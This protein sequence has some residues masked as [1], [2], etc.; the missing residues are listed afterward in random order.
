MLVQDAE[1]RRRRLM[2]NHGGTVNML[3]E[4]ADIYYDNLVFEESVRQWT[5]PGEKEVMRSPRDSAQLLEP[6][7]TVGRH[8][9]S[10]RDDVTAS[11]RSG[12]RWTSLGSG[13]SSTS[14][15]LR[16][17]KVGGAM[18]PRRERSAS[19]PPEVLGMLRIDGAPVRGGD[20]H[21]RHTLGAVQYQGSF[22]EILNIHHQI[23]EKP[24][25]WLLRPHPEQI[26]LSKYVGL[27]DAWNSLTAKSSQTVEVAL[28]SMQGS[29]RATAI[30]RPASRPKP[31]VV[32]EQKEVHTTDIGSGADLPVSRERGGGSRDRDSSLTRRKKEWTGDVGTK[33]TDFGGLGYG[34]ELIRGPGLERKP[35]RN[36]VSESSDKRARSPVPASLRK[37]INKQLS[38]L[39]LAKSEGEL[40]LSL[41][42]IA[43]GGKT[44]GQWGSVNDG[45]SD[46]DEKRLKNPMYATMPKLQ[47]LSL[48]STPNLG[49]GEI[50]EA[51]KPPTRAKVG[52]LSHG[53]ASTG[54]LPSVFGSPP[55]TVS[56]YADLNRE[57]KAKTIDVSLTVPH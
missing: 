5:S 24:V 2:P 50:L 52:G 55:V 53:A 34:S 9:A 8:P 4:Q 26:P 28:A 42:G 7:L 57:S 35:A 16:G 10:P 15:S 29:K 3:Q 30:E 31:P 51:E 40:D 49:A 22:N 20:E 36:W 25:D 48:K 47:P 41:G 27:D 13:G 43:M 18:F 33:L 54:V 6:A 21:T 38:A 56:T 14:T 23:E 32:T 19:P 45:A 1:F 37:E 44:L 46:T 39:A 11:W 12:V 17:A